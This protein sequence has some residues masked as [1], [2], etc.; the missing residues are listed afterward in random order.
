[1][2]I[3][4][5]RPDSGFTIIELLLVIVL[6]V[7][8]SA[9]VIFTFSSVRAKNR[10]AERQ[11]DINALQ[12]QLESFYAVYSKYPTP[13]DLTNA[14]WRQHNLKKLPAD[15]LQDPRWSKGNKD[16]TLD[17]QAVPAT[18]PTTNCYSYQPLGPNNA[19]CDD[20][21]V[22][23]THYTITALLEGGDKYS[24]TSLNN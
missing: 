16:C 9:L 18:Q 3:H 6:V 20:M 13:K 15:G 24:K 19:V 22:D 5:R 10:N 14:A 4:L 11:A 21:T 7:I 1:M 17:G 23:C 2:K 12:A 8:L